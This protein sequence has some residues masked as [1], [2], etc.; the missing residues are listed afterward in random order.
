QRVE[1]VIEKKEKF[2][3]FITLSPGVTGLLPKS[4]ISQSSQSAVIEKLKEGN[5]IPVVITDISSKE[6]KMTLAPGTSGDEQDWQQFA[7][8][9]QSSLGAL[10]EKLQEALVS[11][12]QK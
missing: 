7:K 11:K 4:K 12:K 10:G 1:G 2:G 3:Y 9:D 6:R 5:A 8:E